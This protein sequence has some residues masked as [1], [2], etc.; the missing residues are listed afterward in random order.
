[1]RMLLVGVADESAAMGA[2]FFSEMHFHTFRYFPVP[3]FYFS[4]VVFFCCAT[5]EFGDFLTKHRKLS[6]QTLII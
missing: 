2:P 5:R 3:I 6:H 1:M 4:P